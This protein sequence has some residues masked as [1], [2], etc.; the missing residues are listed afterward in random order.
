MEMP[1]QEQLRAAGSPEGYEPLP[2]HKLVM[3]IDNFPFGSCA[4]ARPQCFEVLDF[5]GL[6]S[7]PGAL[8]G[9]RSRRLTFVSDRAGVLAGFAIFIT[10][11]MTARAVAA[12]DAAETQTPASC[13]YFSRD[14]P[15]P[16]IGFCSAWRDSHWGNLFIRLSLVSGGTMHVERGDI[17]DVNA[18]VDLTPFQPTYTL[19]AALRQQREE[20]VEHTEVLD[21]V[22]EQRPP[23]SSP[24]QLNKCGHHPP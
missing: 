19:H 15:A 12:A 24:W 20:K 9:K 10:G 2:Q 3:A 5:A 11:E 21:G 17:I 22:L 14:V 13:S 6:P 1:T 7:D 23:H 18:T 16:G 4:I 8:T